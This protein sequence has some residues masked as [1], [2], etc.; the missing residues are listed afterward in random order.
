MSETRTEYRVVVDFDGGC[1]PLIYDG[2]DHQT[3]CRISVE[4]QGDCPVRIQ[5]R[6]VTE[7]PWEDVSDED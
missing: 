1:E 4:E 3:A 2:L 7:S 6:T 5:K